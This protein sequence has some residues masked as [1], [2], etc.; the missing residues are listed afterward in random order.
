MSFANTNAFTDSGGRVLILVQIIDLQ[1][2][3][4][5]G[6]PAPADGTVYQVRNVLV[7]SLNP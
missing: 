3:G 6:Q 5:S 4:S 2:E 7:T 1:M